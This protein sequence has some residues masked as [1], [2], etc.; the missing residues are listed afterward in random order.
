M[1]WWGETDQA[2]CLDLSPSFPVCKMSIMSLHSAACGIKLGT[3]IA[4][5]YLLN[6]WHPLLLLLL[7]SRI[8]C[9]LKI[10][11]Q[12]L[13]RFHLKR[14]KYNLVTKEQFMQHSNWLCIKATTFKKH[15]W[16]GTF[17]NYMLLFLIL[18]QPFKLETLIVY[19]L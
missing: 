5:A 18:S 10:G 11:S 2:T 7:L 17:V 16:F 3:Y 6:M 12:K 8:S 13:E 15:I 1:A 9:V 4:S 19:L 14:L